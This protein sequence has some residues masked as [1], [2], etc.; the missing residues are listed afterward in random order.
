MT[1]LEV[2]AAGVKGKY[3]FATNVLKTVTNFTGIF[4]GSNASV[5]K[6][7]FDYNITFVDVGEGNGNGADFDD[8]L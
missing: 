7:G 5:I 3:I 2:E 6:D 8:G 1:W 4:S